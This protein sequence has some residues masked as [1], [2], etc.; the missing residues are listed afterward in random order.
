MIPKDGILKVYW[1]KDIKVI[2]VNMVQHGLFSNAINDSRPGIE[3]NNLYHIWFSSKIL[4]IVK[5]KFI[6]VIRP[7]VISTLQIEVTHNQT[8]STIEFMIIT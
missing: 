8:V 1:V 2:K 7:K 4:K 6:G 3:V 5:E